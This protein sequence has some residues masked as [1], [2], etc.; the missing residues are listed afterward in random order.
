MAFQLSYWRKFLFMK[1]WMSIVGIAIICF[2]SSCVR[3]KSSGINLNGQWIVSGIRL[4]GA[5]NPADYKITLFDDAS[6]ACFTGS[7]WFLTE[8]GNATYTIAQ[9]NDCT[10]GARPIHWSLLN[11]NG[12]QYFQFKNIDNAKAR[13]VTDG[14]RLELSN[15]TKSG[16]TLRDPVQVGNENAYVVL[17]FTRK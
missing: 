3:H 7:E 5:G 9:S 1:K 17:D 13:K 2:A 12:V 10:G 11:S 15:V 14:Y 6:S 16:F 4:N 8:S